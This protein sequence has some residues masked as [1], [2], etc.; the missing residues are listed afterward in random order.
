[1]KKIIA[2]SLVAVLV[3]TMGVIAFAE[4]T[5]EAPQWF[6]DMIKWKKEQVNQ[7][8]EDKTI[9]EEDAKLWNDRI[10][11]MEEYHEENE[12]AFPGGCVGGARGGFGRGTRGARG[13]FGPGMMGGYY[14]NTVAPRIAQ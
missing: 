5:T 7:A 2:V 1:M 9:T 10:D 14:N 6:D 3:L 11:Y 4:S 12:F 13:G 8:V